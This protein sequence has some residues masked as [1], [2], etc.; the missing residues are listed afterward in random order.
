[1]NKPEVV[2]VG[3]CNYRYGTRNYYMTIGTMKKKKQTSGGKKYRPGKQVPMLTTAAT[4]AARAMDGTNQLSL[5]QF[6]DFP[7]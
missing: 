5:P 1:M 7:K 4:A 2:K 3:S 6:G